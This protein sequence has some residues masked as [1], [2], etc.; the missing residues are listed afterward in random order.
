ML[1]SKHIERDIVMQRKVNETRNNVFDTNEILWLLKGN[2][3]MT[4]LKFVCRY[5]LQV[6]PEHI[7][8]V[9]EASEQTEVIKEHKFLVQK[10]IEGEVYTRI[11]TET[12][13]ISYLNMIDCSDEEYRIYDITVFGKVKEVFYRGWQPNCLIEIIDGNGNTIL[14]GYG[15]DH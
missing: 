1:C 4:A 13:L 5:I 14:G 3:K 10:H 7:T 9:L 15:T 6:E 8:D 2:E 12:E 11:C